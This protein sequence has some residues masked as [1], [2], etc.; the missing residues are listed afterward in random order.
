MINWDKAEI[1]LESNNSSRLKL[2]A[3]IVGV[4]LILAA[5]SIL[6]ARNRVFNVN[7]LWGIEYPRKNLDGKM[8][9]VQGDIVFEPLSDFRFNNVFLI[10]SST[11]ADLRTPEY[12]FWFGV[13]VGDI[14]CV[15]NK[16][17]L[18]FACEP[19][20]PSQAAIYQFRGVIHV[21]QIGKKEI[22]WLSDIDLSR[23]R[24]WV[25]G[26]WQAIP[27]GEFIIP[28]KNE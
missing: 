5:A 1:V 8:V 3:G 15:P 21:E 23:S 24:Q 20:D 17:P 12:G 7:D 10:D 2:I 25:K 19:F 14:S 9:T 22:M 11:A 6:W 4:I 26:K 18:S 28:L 16:S 27:K 13:G